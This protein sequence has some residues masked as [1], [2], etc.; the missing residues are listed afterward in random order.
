MLINC[1]SSFSKVKDA[2]GAEVAE[3]AGDGKG[4]EKA[5]TTRVLGVL[6][7]LKKLRMFA[8]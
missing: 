7:K 3:G 6:L 2:K 5:E 8:K 1:K 4:V